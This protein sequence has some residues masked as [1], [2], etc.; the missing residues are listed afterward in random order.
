M[1]SIKLPMT[2]TTR[3]IVRREHKEMRWSHLWLRA[4]VLLAVPLLT[5]YSFTRQPPEARGIVWAVVIGALGVGAV[6]AI[7]LTV[8]HRIGERPIRRDVASSYY[9]RTT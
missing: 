9:L 7:W 2:D 5:A 6:I 4:A 8:A 1:G 3:A